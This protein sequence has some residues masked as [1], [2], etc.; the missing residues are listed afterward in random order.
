MLSHIS[1]SSISSK[2]KYTITINVQCRLYNYTV[3]LMYICKNSIYSAKCTMINEHCTA[4]NKK[5]TLYSDA[6][7]TM[8]SSQ[9]QWTMYIAQY[10]LFQSQ[11]YTVEYQC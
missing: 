7:C 10:T 5:Y 11:M 9:Y 1:S 6:Q 4:H 8:Y 3:C 2:L